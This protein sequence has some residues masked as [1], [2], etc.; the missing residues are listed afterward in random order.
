MK[1]E[2]F[3]DDNIVQNLKHHLKTQDIEKFLEKKLLE[4]IEDYLLGIHMKGNDKTFS[5]NYGIKILKE[6][7]AN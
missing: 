1:I 6:K 3:L 5:Y 7:I 4:E 2:I